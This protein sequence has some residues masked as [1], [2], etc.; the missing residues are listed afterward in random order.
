PIPK[1]PTESGPTKSKGHVGFFTDPNG[2]QHEIYHTA[3]GHLHRAPASTPIA[4]DT[5]HRSGR[6]EATPAMAEGRAKQLMQSANQPPPDYSGSG[7]PDAFEGRQKWASALAP[8]HPK[9]VGQLFATRS[10][11]D[12][13]IG[14]AERMPN[15]KDPQWRE[16]ITA[17]L[18]KVYDREASFRPT[19]PPLNF[20]P[21]VHGG[22]EKSITASDKVP[23]SRPKMNYGSGRHSFSSIDDML[24]KKL[25]D[26][27]RMIAVAELVM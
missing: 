25:T 3:G 17:E 15:W 13:A 9:E 8:N 6:F 1:P 5:G 20:K 24:T 7:N 16:S 21:E 10:S 23:T 14:A 11:F 18:K 2:V 26:L 4:I 22:R 19:P 27:D 12:Q